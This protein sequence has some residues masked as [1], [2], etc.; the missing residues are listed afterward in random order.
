M[1]MC[2]GEYFPDMPCLFSLQLLYTS[3]DPDFSVWPIS[4]YSQLLASKLLDRL[5]VC[6]CVCVCVCVCVW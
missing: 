1:C 5:N 6:L 3:F 4:R 2:V